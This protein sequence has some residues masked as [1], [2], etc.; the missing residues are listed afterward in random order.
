ME[1]NQVINIYCSDS[2]YPEVL[3]VFNIE[4]FR[5]KEGELLLVNNF[6]FKCFKPRVFVVVLMQLYSDLSSDFQLVVL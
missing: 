5:R 4:Q 1:K 2:A 6:Y 3:D